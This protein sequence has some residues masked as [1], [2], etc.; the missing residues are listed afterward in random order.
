MESD[1]VRASLPGASNYLAKAMDLDE[2]AILLKISL[3]LFI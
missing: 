2:F 3:R 1:G